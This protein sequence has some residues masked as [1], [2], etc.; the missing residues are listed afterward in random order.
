MIVLPILDCGRGTSEGISRRKEGEGS[1]EGWCWGY[2]QWFRWP[3]AA[4]GPRMRILRSQEEEEEDRQTG[5][6][7]RFVRHSWS[8]GCPRRLRNNFHRVQEDW[9][10][11][12]SLGLSGKKR[13]R[14]CLKH[15]TSP[16][17]H[18]SVI[19]W[20]PSVAGWFLH[21]Y[22]RE[23]RSLEKIFKTV[24]WELSYPAN[25]HLLKVI[26]SSACILSQATMTSWSKSK[27]HIPLENW[28]SIVKSAENYLW[29]V[30]VISTHSALPKKIMSLRLRFDG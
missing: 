3:A 11:A 13:I 30:D 28:M 4:W 1:D 5:E 24:A 19:L 17:F 18:D 23:Q 12:C 29:L 8:R 21:N 6:A 7:Q 14:A 9:G 25:V 16:V 22:Q 10:R 15:L 20:L 27:F 26:N 2:I